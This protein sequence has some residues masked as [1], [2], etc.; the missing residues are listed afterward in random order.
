MLPPAKV[1][2]R[3]LDDV[4]PS[5]NGARPTRGDRDWP[6]SLVLSKS[7]MSSDDHDDSAQVCTLCAQLE[8]AMAE[9]YHL[10]AQAHRQWDDLYRLWK[11]TAREEENHARQFELAGRMVDDVEALRITGQQAAGLVAGMRQIIAEVTSDPPKPVAALEQAIRLEERLANFH[12]TGI[13]SFSKPNARRLFEAMMA[14]DRDHVAA[15][16]RQLDVE[17]KRG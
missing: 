4:A 6:P 17:R 11:K 16:Q 1:S 13:A 3:R 2:R 12:L 5:P 7:R 14:A 9:V 10:F 15:L 8:H